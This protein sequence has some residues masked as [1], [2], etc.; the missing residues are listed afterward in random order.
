MSWRIEAPSGKTLEL[1]QPQDDR[2]VTDSAAAVFD[3]YGFDSDE[4]ILAAL[5]HQEKVDMV[6]IATGNRLSGMSGYHSNPQTALAEWSVKLTSFVNGTQGEGM[7]LVN[8]DRGESYEGMFTRVGW[9]RQAG[10]K[11]QVAWD[12]TFIRG[13]NQMTSG[14][15]SPPSVSPNSNPTFDGVS[16]GSIESW[17]EDKKQ[18]GGIYPIAL[19]DPGGNQVL[20]SGGATRKVMITGKVEGDTATRNSFDSTMKAKVGQDVT[21]TL[22]TGFPGRNLTCMLTNFE[23]T[24]KA[25]LTR[26]GE[27]SAE[28][29]EGQTLTVTQ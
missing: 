11:Y 15:T 3:I 13:Q 9:Q 16:L 14:D 5:Q 17:R 21:G 27:Y 12:L 20:P 1:I 24:R 19:A 25:G 28:F 23:G 6:G 7:T 8:E 26:I 22:D 18:A 10:E 4:A 2:N 29:M